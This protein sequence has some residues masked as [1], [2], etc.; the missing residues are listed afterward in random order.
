MR[1]LALVKRADAVTLGNCAAGLVSIFFVLQGKFSQAAWALLF[2]AALDYLDGKVA[3]FFHE[4]NVLGR[5]LD[6]LADIVSFGVGPAVFVFALFAAYTGSGFLIVIAALC[7]V[8]V[9]CGALRLARFNISHLQGAY[10]GMPI[11]INGILFPALWFASAPLWVF[12][13][14]LVASSV[15]MVS[16][17]RIKKIA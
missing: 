17:I 15:L 14:A 2:A 7:F 6:S 13:A 5:E 9:S 10:E 11:T 3:R 4:E 8:F 16:S 1:I 12:A